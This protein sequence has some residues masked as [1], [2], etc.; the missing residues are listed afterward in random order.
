MCS[1]RCTHQNKVPERG[2]MAFW[3]ASD[4]NAT[5]F[6]KHSPVRHAY[7]ASC[8]CSSIFYL[9]SIYNNHICLTHM[10]KGQN[11]GEMAYGLSRWSQS[12]TINKMTYSTVKERHVLLVCFY[13]WLDAGAVWW[14]STILWQCCSHTYKHNVS[15]I[16]QL[17]SFA[18]LW[19]TG[20]MM[21]IH[22]PCVFKEL[23]WLNLTFLL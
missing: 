14:V 8:Y 11:R 21:A 16:A 13:T 7:K 15:Y 5:L 3:P 4:F 9:D 18:Y 2:L 20:S 17:F 19:I 10:Q 22:F 1:E 6:I 12:F 23:M